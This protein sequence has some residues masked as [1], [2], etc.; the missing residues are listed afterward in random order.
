LGLLAYLRF[1]YGKIPQVTE[2]RRLL[3]EEAHLAGQVNEAEAQITATEQEIAAM[4]SRLASGDQAIVSDPAFYSSYE[5]K[6]QKLEALM[7]QWE[8]AHTELESFKTDYM[9]NNDT[10]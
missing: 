10:V 4:D 8:N 5:E 1:N 7:E 2:K 6:K 3:R 9:N